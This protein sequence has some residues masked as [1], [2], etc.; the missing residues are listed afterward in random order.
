MMLLRLRSTA[1]FKGSNFQ[2]DPY[3]FSARKPALSA[4]TIALTKFFQGI[5][6]GTA[7]GPGVN[8]MASKVF[9]ARAFMWR[10]DGGVTDSVDGQLV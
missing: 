8:N 4:L 3:N 5:S 2:T 7:L 9:K 6:P 1:I 10:V